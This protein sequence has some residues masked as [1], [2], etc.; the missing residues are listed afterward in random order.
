MVTAYGMSLMFREIT[1]LGYLNKTD[2]MILVELEYG[3]CVEFFFIVNI[4]YS[5]GYLY[6]ECIDSSWG[7][8]IQT[9]GG[10]I[11]N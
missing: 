1:D 4:W 3:N 6:F 8:Y 5:G 10:F 7:I 2:S 11:L 9:T